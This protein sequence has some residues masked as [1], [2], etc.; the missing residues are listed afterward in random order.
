MVYGVR[1][2]S[3]NN[4]FRIYIQLFITCF[5][6]WKNKKVVRLRQKVFEYPPPSYLFLLQ[7]MPED[8]AKKRKIERVN[9]YR[10]M[11][12][13]YWEYIGCKYN[14]EKT[15]KAKI[16]ELDDDI[17]EAQERRTKPCWR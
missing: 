15:S 1:C 2:S 17:V 3:S 14:M 7:T 13:K 10:Q 9:A 5:L 11:K 12:R 8:E 6:P 4:Q 16:D